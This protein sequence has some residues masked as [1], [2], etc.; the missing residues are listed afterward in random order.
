MELKFRGW[1]K[2]EKLLCPVKTINLEK[3]CFLVGN[4]PTPQQWI[5]DRSY[6]C[7]IKE[8]HFVHFD[9]LILM[10][11]TGLQDK[12]GQDIYEGDVVVFNGKELEIRFGTYIEAWDG[13]CPKDGHNAIGWYMVDKDEKCIKSLLTSWM[14][15]KMKDITVVGNIFETINENV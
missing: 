4:S 1:D 9:D 15:P 13:I 7:E 5:N 8:G 2:K 11:A 14:L 10:E 6:V 12:N 3:G